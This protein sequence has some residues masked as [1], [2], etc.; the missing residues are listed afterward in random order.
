MTKEEIQ[1]LPIQRI[2]DKNCVLFLWVTIPCLLEGLELINKWNFKYKTVAFVWVKTNKKSD[3]LFWGL[4]YYTRANVE[5]C[6]LATK[7]NGLPRVNKGIHQIICSP[8][9]E[10]SRKPDETREK[11]VSLFGNVPKIELFAR[12]SFNG[13]YCWGNEINLFNKRGN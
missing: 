10:H 11:I 3:S 1:K 7:G 8:I 12:E 9:R 4:G 6:L 13:W 2:C 5:L